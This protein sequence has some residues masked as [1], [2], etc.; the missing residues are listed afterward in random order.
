MRSRPAATAVASALMSA[1]LV[2]SASPAAADQTCKSSGE[3]GQMIS[4]FV[5]DLR[6]DVKSK[7]ARAATRT[8]LVESMDTFRGERAET[9]AERRELGEQIAALARR[10]K[11]TGNPVEKRALATAVL[12]LVEQRERGPFTAAERKELRG[13]IAALRRA[14]T[15]R[16]DGAQEREEISA[17]I[18]A[19][20]QQYTCAPS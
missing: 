8:A 15:N 1:T 12:A 10:Q 4:A 18:R 19:I 9:A 3:V 17:A 16:A 2:A 6:D 7:R 5:A 13:S 20:V 14:I 11:Q